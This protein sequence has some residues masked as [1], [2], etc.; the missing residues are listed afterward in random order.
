M[1]RNIVP[2]LHLFPQA[3]IH[4]RNSLNPPRHSFFSDSSFS[5]F[6]TK[7]CPPSK[8]GGWYCEYKGALTDLIWASLIANRKT[9]QVAEK[10]YNKVIWSTQCQFHTFEGLMKSSSERMKTYCSVIYVKGRFILNSITWITVLLLKKH[11]I[12]SIKPI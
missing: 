4:G 10:K 5:K 7:S 11:W 3:N 6:G 8:K 1:T 9:P 12:P 2:P